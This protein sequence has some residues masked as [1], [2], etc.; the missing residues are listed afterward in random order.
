M[1]VAIPTDFEVTGL[2]TAFQ[3]TSIPTDFEPTTEGKT[4]LELT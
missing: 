3:I 4:R 2:R 1:I